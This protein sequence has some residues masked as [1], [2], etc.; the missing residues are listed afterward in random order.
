MSFLNKYHERFSNLLHATFINGTF[1]QRVQCDGVDYPN[2]RFA[3]CPSPCHYKNGHVVWTE[4]E[5]VPELGEPVPHLHW[6][7]YTARGGNIDIEMY[8]KI[9]LQDNVYQ[10]VVMQGFDDVDL[11]Y[12]DSCPYE[13]LLPY[14]YATRGEHDKA[15]EVDEETSANSTVNV[16]Q[17]VARLN[18]SG[19]THARNIKFTVMQCNDMFPN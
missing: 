15:T 2:R 16:E 13:Y 9:R 19:L 12:P 14:L 18:G 6:E 11:M 10:V 4:D 3:P 17:I 1:H 5:Y 7:V 8:V